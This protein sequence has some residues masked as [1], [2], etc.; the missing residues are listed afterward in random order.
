MKIVCGPIFKGWTRWFSLHC[1]PLLL[2]WMLSKFHLLLEAK[3][4]SRRLADQ[5]AGIE[6]VTFTFQC[7]LIKM[8][9]MKKKNGTFTTDWPPCGDWPP[10]PLSTNVPPIF[11]PDECVTTIRRL[12]S[13]AWC[14]TP[15]PEICPHLLRHESDT[16]ISSFSSVEGINFERS[17]T[18]QILPR[19][20]RNCLKVSCVGV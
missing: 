6:K 16:P 10:S 3:L 15:Q 17:V 13:V 19:A 8:L 18:A 9:P 11:L 5:A 7:D 4:T 1:C 2:Q 12:A 14:T 20:F